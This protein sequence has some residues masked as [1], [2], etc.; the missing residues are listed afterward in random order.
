MSYY[1][2]ELNVEANHA[3]PLSIKILLLP[4]VSSFLSSTPFHFSFLFILLIF[5]HFLLIIYNRSPLHQPQPYMSG[6]SM[7]TLAIPPSDQFCLDLWYSLTYLI[8]LLFL[9]LLSYFARAGSGA[10][11]R[12]AWGRGIQLEAKIRRE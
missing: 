11:P 2:L 3:T 9:L 8:H 4:L 12:R 10:R 1:Y 7:Q 5:E 6:P